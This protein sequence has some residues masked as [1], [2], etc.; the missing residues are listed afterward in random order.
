MAARAGLIGEVASAFQYHIN[1][2]FV[3][4]QFSRLLF[5]VDHDFLAVDRQ[6]A[7]AGLNNSRKFSVIAVV[8]K[9]MSQRFD[10]S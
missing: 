4:G 9:Q 8:F 7:T 5:G 10:V 3:P 1:V 2:L 6:P